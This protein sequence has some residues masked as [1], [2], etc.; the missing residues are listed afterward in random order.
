MKVIVPFAITNA[1]LSS[2]SIPEPDTASGAD[3]ALWVS[4]G[5]YAS[6]NLVSRIE[7]HGVYRH[8]DVGGGAHSHTTPPEDDP[9]HWAYVRPT[10]RWSPF[11]EV[12][13]TA[14][15]SVTSMTYVI[16]PG[17]VVS[18]LA[19]FELVANSVT[20][21]VTDGS[22]PPPVYSETF[23]LDETE[24]LDWYGY[25]FTPIT[26]RQALVVNDLP[27]YASATITI[28]I[29][30]VGPVSVGNMVMGIDY[31][32]GSTGYSGASAGIRDY[33]KKVVDEETGYVRV[34]R[35]RF[36]KTMRARFILSEDAVNF[37]H[38]LLS[39]LRST[40]AV[41]IGDNDAGLEPL[42]VYGF[43]KDFQLD[44]EQRKISYY[45]LEIEGMV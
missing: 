24:L 19:F 9:D 15:T 35:R 30:G 33:S 21:E 17:Q 16:E 2:C 8:T 45:S 31:A 42:I 20:I 43:Y 26:T 32:I 13:G 25:F 3:P 5:S 27:P 29:T 40:P 10:N 36:A 28:T 39:D 41:W 11:D 1:T 14:A 23:N 38:R 6:G 7:T 44:L 22:T 37:V 18:S 4:G 12:I 34:E